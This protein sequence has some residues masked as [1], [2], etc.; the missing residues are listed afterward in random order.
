M[1]K[2]A[3]H[4]DG[5]PVTPNMFD[6]HKG[7]LNVANGTVRLRTGEVQEHRREDYLTR[8][9]PVE[10][11]AGAACP[12]W[13]R[14]LEE[15]TGGDA[16]LAHYLQVMVGYMLSGS[17]QE[18]VRLLPLWGRGQRQK[19]LSGHAGRHAGRLCP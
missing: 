9:A 15:I 12:L 8:I 19:H 10:Y 17:T 14:F 5:I 7:L 6:R 13:E 2:E 1:L 16:R 11:S 3:Q 4:L 18:P